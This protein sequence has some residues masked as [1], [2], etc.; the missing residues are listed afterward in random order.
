M[1]SFF[2]LLY[3]PSNSVAWK[4]VSHK[5]P[6]TCPWPRAYKEPSSAS[7]CMW[8]T[9]VQKFLLRS[10]NQTGSPELSLPRT[11]FGSLS[12][13]FPPC[14]SFLLLTHVP[15]FP[16]LRKIS[17]YWKRKNYLNRQRIHHGPVSKLYTKS[18]HYRDNATIQGY[19]Q[20]IDFELPETACVPPPTE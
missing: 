8:L 14:L 13:S 18:R 11:Y 19:E 16:L 10:Q 2:P 15:S 7:P 12:S 1:F 20:V 5:P 4:C 17:S 3:L 6:G 9:T